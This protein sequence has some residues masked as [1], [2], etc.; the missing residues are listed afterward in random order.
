MK[1]K[2]FLA[3]ILGLVLVLSSLIVVFPAEYIKWSNG[4]FNLESIDRLAF[5]LTKYYTINDIKYDCGNEFYFGFYLSF[6][7]DVLGISEE[8]L[9]IQLDK[10]A[11]LGYFVGSSFHYDSSMLAPNRE[12][13]QY[14]KMLLAKCSP[15]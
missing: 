15:D 3:P 5:T 11:K 8:H 6:S 4:E 9:S 13:E 10:G 12:V 2:Y 1:K 14:N 7:K